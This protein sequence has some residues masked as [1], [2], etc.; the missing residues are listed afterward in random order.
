MGLRHELDRQAHAATL[1][2][3]AHLF[4]IEKQQLLHAAEVTALQLELAQ[5]ENA[6]LRSQGSSSSSGPSSSTSLSTGEAAD[7]IFLSSTYYLWSHDL[8]VQYFGPLNNLVPSRVQKQRLAQALTVRAQSFV[9]AVEK[10]FGTPPFIHTF[11]S[12]A[13]A[14]ELTQIASLLLKAKANPTSVY[15]PVPDVVTGVWFGT[16]FFLL[17]L[18]YDILSPLY[19]TTFEALFLAYSEAHC[20]SAIPWSVIMSDFTQQFHAFLLHCPPPGNAL[21]PS[22]TF[23][24]DSITEHFSPTARASFLQGLMTAKNSSIVCGLSAAQQ[25]STTATGSPNPRSG[26]P[27]NPVAKRDGSSALFA[28]GAAAKRGA[29]PPLLPQLKTG[30]VTHTNHPSPKSD[31]CW[32]AIL[33]ND[34]PSI[35]RCSVSGC[36]RHHQFHKDESQS[37]K[38][39]FIAHVKLHGNLSML[40]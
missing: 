3:Q 29:P 8:F 33:E 24:A 36:W 20:L 26:G 30:K 9:T 35:G 13:K 21:V 31:P 34:S 25:T 14:P 2:E 38:D 27:P 22:P 10:P 39:A 11:A 6:H 37:A 19:R 5:S 28:F 32:R 12:A 15:T 7:A 18:I 40:S 4:S 23:L 16:M 17:M 1:K